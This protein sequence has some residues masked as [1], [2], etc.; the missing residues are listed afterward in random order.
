M[1]F[2]TF[3]IDDNS[4]VNYSGDRRGR[5]HGDMLHECSVLPAAIKSFRDSKLL[6]R[7]NMQD[8]GKA[9]SA[10]GVRA[11]TQPVTGK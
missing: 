1:L 4:A 9:P 10:I 7:V 5:N 8:G 3:R 11:K 6:Q 2:G